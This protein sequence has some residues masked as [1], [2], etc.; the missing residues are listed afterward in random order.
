[1]E[2]H[3]GVSAILKEKGGQVST[4]RPDSTVYDA[5]VLMAQNEIGSLLVMDNG[6]LVGLFSE[7]D[8]ARK[9]ALHGR[10]SKETAVKEVMV[11]PPITVSPD[12]S[13]AEAMRIMTESRVRHLPVVDKDGA[14]VGIISIGDAVKWIISSQ[15]KTI[16][17]LQSY[18]TGTF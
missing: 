6:R 13:I 11:S 2:V 4:V 15:E 7:R 16:E 5:L 17:H 3:E 14:T 8:Y 18:I 10:S 1:M 9:I 12:C